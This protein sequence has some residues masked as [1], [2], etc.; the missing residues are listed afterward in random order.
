[1]I[2]L[3]L[4]QLELV[5]I[6]SCAL[7]VGLYLRP[8][9]TLATVTAIGL[10]LLRPTAFGEQTA[11]YGSV[12][13]VL[14][15]GLYLLLNVGEW[16]YDAATSAMLGIVL[17]GWFWL[18]VHDGTVRG[19]SVN[20]AGTSLTFILPIIALL[21][22]GPGRKFYED[23]R[24]IIVGAV[25]VSAA[26]MVLAA[27]IGLVLGFSRISAGATHFGY[28]TVSGNGVLFPG[29]MVY[30]S[31]GTGEIPRLLGL[32]REP[33]M[34]A[35]FIGWSYF[36]IPAD[37][38]LR[39]PI[40]AVL[41]VAL[42][43]TQS[44]AGVALFAAAWGL[45]VLRGGKVRALA[46]RFA[47]SLMVLGGLLL[48]ALAPEFGLLEKV[49]SGSSFSDRWAATANGIHALFSTPFDAATEVPM[50]SIN[51]I[52]GIAATGLPWFVLMCTFFVLPVV[53]SRIT[54]WQQYA[55]LLVFGTVLL[56]QPA[57][58]STGI[59]AL[60]LVSCFTIPESRWSRVNTP[61]VV[62]TVGKLGDS[63]IPSSS[64]A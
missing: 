61:E 12:L 49:D 9:A 41:L 16:R 2:A 26:L 54:D 6:A 15:S 7:A 1:M 3:D 47:I 37:W 30:G 43:L 56:A 55:A 53:R 48:A 42:L 57:L 59:L 4:W 44:T 45:Q 24:R 29:A 13:V 35:L 23:L 8:V 27:G 46:T 38:R 52:A 31:G 64:G 5:A 18:A 50:A 40:R 58:D 32:G 62:G 33:G 21:L 36:A 60:T 14:G 28:E 34:G 63:A 20:L 51:L 19:S 11:V 17:L 25:A 10:L 22:V 39:M